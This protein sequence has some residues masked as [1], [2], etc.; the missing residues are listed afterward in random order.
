MKFKVLIGSTMAAALLGLGV[1]LGSVAGPSQ[2]GA[3]TQ[4]AQ[5]PAATATPKAEQQAPG[6][7]D[8]H[9]GMPFGDMH[10]GGKGMRGGFGH[11]LGPG[12][13]A[14]ADNATRAISNTTTIV[15]L[16]KGD[17]AYANGKMDTADVQRWVNGAES[18]LG[19]AQSANGA[20]NYE[21]AVVYSH[22]A[23][24]LAATA[25]TGMA[26]KLG[27]D[28]L[29]SYSQRP[30]RGDRGMGITKGVPSSAD[31]SQARVSRLLA[32]TYNRIVGAGAVVSGNADALTYITDAQAQYRAAYDA[33][34]AGN[35]ADAAM[36]ARLANELTEVALTLQRATLSPGTSGAP[37][38]VPAPNF[39]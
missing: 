27:A 33:Y 37:V 38:Q 16:V 17:L 14:T 34:Q 7:G 9:G 35:Y 6:P 30:M 13:E 23:M 25:Y 10:R 19:K 29:P 28:Q 8:R 11:G 21:Q 39:P 22:A 3:Q 26:Q 20:S 24:R 1:M 36:S 15:N 12:R 32:A 5:T 2:A 31:V 4:Q 18:L